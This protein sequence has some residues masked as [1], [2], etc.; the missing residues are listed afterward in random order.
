MFEAGEERGAVAQAMRNI[1][2]PITALRPMKETQ[3]DRG[4]FIFYARR[5]ARLSSRP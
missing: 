4:S 2:E 1:A 3:E 5:A